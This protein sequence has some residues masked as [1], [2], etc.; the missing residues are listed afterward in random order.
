[1][2]AFFYEKHGYDL[3]VNMNYKQFLEYIYERH[4]GNVKLGLER[5]LAI[6]NG[7]G[8][9]ENKLQGFHVAG[10]N[11][12]GSTSAMLEKIALEHGFTT[13]LNTSPHLVDYCERIRI[14]GS[15][16]TPERLLAL[17]EK[18]QNLFQ[19]NEASFFEITT[20]MAF[21]LF[22]TQ[23]VECTIFEVG[24]GGRL[25]GTN[26][27][28]ADIA[29]ITSVS[30]DHV[31]S[32]GNTLTKIAWEKAGI[33]KPKQKVI[34]GAI[35]NEAKEV[36]RQVAA[37]K[38]AQLIEM[39][40]SFE[41]TNIRLNE[42]GTTFNYK[43]N[44]VTFQD[45]QVNLLGEHQAGNASLAI[46]AFIEWMQKKE[47]N[48]DENKLRRAL[49]KIDWKGRM[50]ILNQKPTV[51]IDGAHNVEGVDKLV[52]NIKKIFPDKKIFTVL[53]ILRDKNLFEMIS[54]ITE[55]SD[56]LYISKN[57]SKRAAEIEDQVA[58]AEKNG[59]WYE[60]AYDVETALKRAMLAAENEDII[61]IAGSL[62]TISEVLAAKLF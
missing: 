59:A 56:R 12:K 25:D 41:I 60:T 20:A 37:D 43:Y 34:L 5:M 62:Y 24:L 19:S 11:G 54:R 30:Y 21:Y 13:G 10:T 32:L 3:G 17:Y 16:I 47:Q 1:M 35:P 53:A 31:K 8:N 61:V 44:D 50:Q 26:P 27:F 18:W 15:N 38:N 48:I 7:M 58:V 28:E 46:T 40:N 57:K 9:P 14:N 49:Q 23:K 29:I 39:H 6:L 42:Y 51:I 22:W 52:Y 36:I 55:M 2:P 45:L 4:S 33:I